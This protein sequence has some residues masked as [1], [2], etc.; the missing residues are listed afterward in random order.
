MKMVKMKLPG[1]FLILLLSS[2]IT[3]AQVER[4]PPAKTDSLSG[5]S[6]SGKKDLVKDLDL[7]TGQQAKLKE[8]RQ[9]IKMK[10]KAIDNNDQLTDEERKKQVRELQKEQA[11]YIEGILTDEQK[12]KFR[13]GRKK[14]LKKN[15]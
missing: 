12:E 5:T 15:S 11:K 6:I 13:T 3:F 4:V 7:S 14:A 1:L 10:R 8:I 2:V 9:T